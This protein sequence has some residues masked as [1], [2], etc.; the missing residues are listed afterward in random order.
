MD[1]PARMHGHQPW[2]L[3]NRW[4]IAVW[5]RELKLRLSDHLERWEWARRGREIQERG[6]TRT[7]TVHSDWHM[8]N[9]TNIVEQESFPCK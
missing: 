8:T 1:R 7:P 5:L 9:Q 2:E 4:E 3:D 6:A